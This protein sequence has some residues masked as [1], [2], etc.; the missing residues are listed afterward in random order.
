MFMYYTPDMILIAAAVIPVFVLLM[1]ARR[2][3]RAEAEPP[4]LLFSLSVMGIIATTLAKLIERVGLFVLNALLPQRAL[5]YSIFLYFGLVAYAEEG[6]K[7]ALLK[8][9]TWRSPDF[10]C[11]FDGVVYAVFVSLGFALWEN[12][13]YVLMNG[14]GTAFM[15]AVTAI[16]GHACFGVFMGCWYAEAAAL[17]RRGDEPYSRAARVLAVV[18]PALLHGA[19][20][21]LAAASAA[22]AWV[23][24]G[25]VAV[26]FGIT[27]R[28]VRRLSRADQYV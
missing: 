9:A 6:A 20:D 14:L 11:R 7:Y 3:D 23:F 13:G 22:S 4:R 5:L 21:F 19:Y 8:H 10:D 18:I 2:Q 1:L 16:P 25:F 15:R 12:I 17:D 27:W 24:L 28:L 26:M